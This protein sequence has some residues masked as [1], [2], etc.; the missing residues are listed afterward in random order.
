MR[1]GGQQPIEV[2]SDERIRRK[3]TALRALVQAASEIG[4][5]QPA[6]TGFVKVESAA[7]ENLFSVGK[8]AKEVGHEFL[9]DRQD[10]AATG[11]VGGQ[12]ERRHAPSQRSGQFAERI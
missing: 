3:S 4:S 10:A 5:D 12:R 9:A 1:P 2:C 7:P 6:L 11:V 8:P